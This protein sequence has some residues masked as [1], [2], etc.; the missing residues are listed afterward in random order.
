MHVA[1]LEQ[2]KAADHLALNLVALR[3]ARGLT[4]DDLASRAGLSRSH[5]RLLE[6]G[7]SSNGQ[8][9][10]PRLGTLEA[11]ATSLG[12]GFE[13]LL[14]EPRVRALYRWADSDVE[15]DDRQESTLLDRLLVFSARHLGDRAAAFVAHDDTS[16]TMGVAVPASSERTALILTEGMHDEALRRAGV[17]AVLTDEVEM[18]DGLD[19]LVGAE[20]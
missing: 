1:E 7:R 2:G 8:P 4:Q 6:A 10:N 5:Y 9:A 14:L 11:L 16:V 19:G 15:I 13:D 3:T 12:V 17:R 18:S 20:A